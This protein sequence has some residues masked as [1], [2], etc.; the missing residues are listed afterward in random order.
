MSNPLGYGVSDAVA[1]Q[2]VTSLES[3]KGRWGMQLSFAPLGA[4]SDL[5]SGHEMEAA[6]FMRIQKAPFK[7]FSIKGSYRVL[8]VPSASTGVG[9]SYHGS[10]IG[11][12]VGYQ[13]GDS[14]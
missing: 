14:L 6:V 9:A 11:F 10:Q 4:T 5:F 3:A 12:T 8:D 1:P 7:K 13:I 2:I